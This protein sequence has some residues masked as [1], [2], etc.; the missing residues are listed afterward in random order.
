MII[1]VTIDVFIIVRDIILKRVTNKQIPNAKIRLE[2]KYKR[3]GWYPFV[4]KNE[5][6]NGEINKRNSI[7]IRNI[8]YFLFINK[9]GTIEINNKG[10][11]K[12]SFS[13]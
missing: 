8:K 2:V 10:I 6:R 3:G 11:S 4:I 5:T 7:K 1:T 12:N 9:F 13:P